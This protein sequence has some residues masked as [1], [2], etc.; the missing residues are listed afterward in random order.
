M[1]VAVHTHHH[2]APAPLLQQLGVVA[3]DE[4]IEANATAVPV[5]C[6][7]VTDAVVDV[8]SAC[9]QVVAGTNYILTMRVALPSCRLLNNNIV[10]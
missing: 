8:S 6:L 9:S 10:V 2:G 7:N 5:G 4:I 3:W 1:I